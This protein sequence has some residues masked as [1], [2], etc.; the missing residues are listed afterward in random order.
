MNQ[1]NSKSVESWEFEI[2]I[3]DINFLRQYI[4][5][6][7]QIGNFIIFNKLIC[8]IMNNI[9]SIYDI[10]EYQFIPSFKQIQDESYKKNF[11]SNNPEVG[12]YIASITYQKELM[13]LNEEINK[14]S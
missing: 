4:S 3:E 12:E 7:N 8:R 13:K 14:Y 6:K 10:F 1:R 9:Y 5:E 11:P 2:E